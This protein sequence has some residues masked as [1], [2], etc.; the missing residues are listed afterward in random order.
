MKKPDL[1]NHKINNLFYRFLLPSIG[2]SLVTS[3]Y[4]LTDTIM[5]GRGVGADGI[6]ALNILLP[7]FAL[8]HA[9]GFL[10]GIGGG[11]LMSVENGKGKQVACQCLFYSIGFFANYFSIIYLL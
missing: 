1:L 5:I 9:T 7:L 10:F 3:V 11:V 6:V 2:S 8:F 4:V